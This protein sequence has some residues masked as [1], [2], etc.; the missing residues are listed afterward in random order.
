MKRFVI[1]MFQ[2]K[3]RKQRGYSNYLNRQDLD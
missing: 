1:L 2:T 3:T